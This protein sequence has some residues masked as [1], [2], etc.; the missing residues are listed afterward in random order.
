[1]PP[2]VCVVCERQTDAPEDVPVR[3][4]VR[5]F[6]EERFAYWRCPGCGS[7]HAR[8]DVDLARYYARYPFHDLPVDFRLHAMYANFAARMERAGVRRDARVLDYGC[9]G[10][11]LVRYLRSRGY[12][13]VSGFDEYS[14]DF[15]DRAV[16]ERRYDCIVSQDVIEHV[17]E[18]HALLESFERLAEPGGII[19]VGTPNATAIDLARS[20]DFVHTIH[21]PYHRHILSR[22]A[23]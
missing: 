14:R 15:G 6:R 21:A 16:L 2:R 18:P 20:E 1:M 11:A 12:T 9:G 4:N 22:A 7:L 8:D 19:V 3:S 13:D 10:G 23:L 5:A 17:A